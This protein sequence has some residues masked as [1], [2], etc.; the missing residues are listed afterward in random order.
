MHA[1]TILN[2][3]MKSEVQATGYILKHHSGVSYQ[4]GCHKYSCETSTGQ[5]IIKSY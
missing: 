1:S 4:A 3:T 2:P 5:Q